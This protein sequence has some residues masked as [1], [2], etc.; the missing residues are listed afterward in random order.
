MYERKDRLLYF[1]EDMQPADIDNLLVDVEDAIRE[2]DIEYAYEL[3]LHATQL[4]P[5]NFEV[6][7]ARASLASS[8]DEKI[9]CMNYLNELKPD[10]QD[11]YHFT[12]F[13]LKEILDR[14][15]FLAYLEETEN[16]YRV[17]NTERMVLSIPKKRSTI[18]RY[19][20]NEVDRLTAAKR[21]LILAI[22]G[23]LLAGIGTLIFAPLAV[24]EALN[25]SQIM[26]SRAGQASS[27][28][29]LAASG[30]IFLFG[31]FFSFIFI[32]HLIG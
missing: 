16:L 8:L 26:R 27:L 29:T 9:L 21:Y 25:A 19:F 5:K 4:V 2:G 1:P 32:L 12:F 23:L 11:R 24:W 14:D 22:F 18:T 30:V 31:L 20:H 6:W 17:H 3:S 10:H 7:L 13:V 28:I 15:P